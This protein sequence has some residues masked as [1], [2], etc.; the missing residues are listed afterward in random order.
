MDF[1]VARSAD[2][3]SMT[4]AGAVVGTPAYMSP[5]QARGE[6]ADT[7]SDLF[8]LGIIFYELLT[9][10]VPFEAETVVGMLLKRCQEL[11]T[12]PNQVDSSIPQALSDIV[13]KALAMDPKSRYQRR[14]GTDRGSWIDGRILRRSGRDGFRHA[15]LCWF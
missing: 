10:I 4:R 9:G 7:R 5:E 15:T 12:P 13:M 1:G 3:S 11:A 2:G 8:S 6:K 14:R